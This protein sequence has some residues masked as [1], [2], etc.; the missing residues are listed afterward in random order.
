MAETSQFNAQSGQ[1]ESDPVAHASSPDMGTN[2]WPGTV[3]PDPVS[4]GML[5]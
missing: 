5:V 4:P 2:A 1:P 3:M